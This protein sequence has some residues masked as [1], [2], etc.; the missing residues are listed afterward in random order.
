MASQDLWTAVVTGGAAGIG[1][2]TVKKL[3]SR[4]VNVLIADVQ[5]E[6]GNKLAAEIKSSFGVD[7]A[8][9]HVDVSKEE[10]VQA[11]IKMVVDKW[12][13]LDYAANV[14]GF[15]R[16]DRNNEANVSTAEFDKHFAVNQR[17][18][19]LCQK[20]EAAQMLKQEPRT[21]ELSPKP[22]LAINPQR[23]AI[24]NVG[25]TTA[26][27]GMGF[28]AYAPTKAAV[29]EITR[30]GA[31]FY[32]PRGIRCNAICPGGTVTDMS[33]ANSTSADREAY[34]KPIALKVMACPEEQASVISFLLSPESSHVTGNVIMVDGGFS[35]T[36]SG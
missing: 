26:V 9:R 32:S 24:V 3:A 10:E 19:W 35:S 5:D 21:V 29:L 18:V 23:G 27:T 17:G 11:M 15:C 16:E 14:A 12:G 6:L 28:P 7:A 36:M 31:F 20:H 22:S 33:A 2:A 30:N 8:F 1:A 25:S 34:N 4:G 13:R